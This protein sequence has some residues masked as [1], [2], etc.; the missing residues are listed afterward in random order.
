MLRQMSYSLVGP[1]SEQTLRDLNA[2]HVF[3]GVDGIDLEIG[4]S[5]PDVFESQLNALMI[6]VAREVT[7]VSDASKFGRRSLSV[8]SRI[9]TVHR[10]ITDDK[11]TPDVISQLQARNIEVMVV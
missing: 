7:V 6:K 8:I 5:T 9:D 4:L 2:H 10:V 11:V 1:Q 3:L